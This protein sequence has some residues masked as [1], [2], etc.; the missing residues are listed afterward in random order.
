[1]RLNGY[2]E[3]EGISFVPEQIFS[4]AR[5]QIKDNPLGRDLWRTNKPL[6]NLL[7]KSLSAPVLQLALKPL[8]LGL[9]QWMTV[10]PKTASSLQ[11]LFC[12]QGLAICALFSPSPPPSRSPKLGIL[13]C[14]GSPT[15]VL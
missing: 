12:I 13:P 6:S 4:S 8:R 10:F 2:I 14:P 5:E 7:L 3:L 1:F 9:D 15:S 11:D